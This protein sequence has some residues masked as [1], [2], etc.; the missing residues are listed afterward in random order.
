[1]KMITSQL[2]VT[3]NQAKGG[4]GSQLTLAKENDGEHGFQRAGQGH[5]RER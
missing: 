4:V 2:G 3:S 1:M 5:S